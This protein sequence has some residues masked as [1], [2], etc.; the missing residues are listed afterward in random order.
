MRPTAE[1]IV[2]YRTAL[3]TGASSG[4]GRALAKRIAGQGTEL[5]ICA[6]RVAELESLAEEIR[7]AGGRVHVRAVDVANTHA[8]AEAVRAA[9]AEVH[10][11]DLVIANAGVGGL[12]PT[13]SLT[14]E[15]IEKMCLVNF[16]GAIATLTAV[17]PEMVKRRRGHIVGVSSLAAYKPLPDSAAYCA[18]KRG[19]SMFLDAVRMDLRGTGVEVTT[20]HPGFVRTAMTAKNPFPMPFI[21]D[22]DEAVDLIV[23]KL[24]RAPAV[25]DFS[26]P[27]DRGAR[28]RAIDSPS[29]VGARRATPAAP[30]LEHT[31][32]RGV[33]LA[34]FA[35]S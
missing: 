8:A 31:W 4:I 18:S 27:A 20:I 17:L 13:K 14:W 16:S 34:S 26:A 33:Q 10:G 35:A 7:T 22:L 32:Q 1:A 15:S 6:R 23:R 21:V 12:T 25:I 19:L 28:V 5:V 24:P 11:L 3:I 9:D 2:A 29:G 30:Q